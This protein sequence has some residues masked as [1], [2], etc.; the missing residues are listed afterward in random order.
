MQVGVMITNGGPHPAEKWAQVT[1]DQIIDIGST[2]KGAL[3]TE[4]HTFRTMIVQTLADHHTKVQTHERGQ[5]E[6]AGDDHLGTAL[7]PTAH[8]AGAV[9][10]IIEATKG[11]SFEAHFAQPHVREYLERVLGSHFA[12]S[13]HIERSW[14]ADRNPDGKNAQAFRAAH[15]PGTEA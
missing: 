15:H 11:T 5:L 1:A 9:D 8:I 12:T 4:A 13:M 3:L 14:H 6:S 10:E 2:A 7:D